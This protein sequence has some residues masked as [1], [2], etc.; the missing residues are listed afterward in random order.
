MRRMRHRGLCIDLPHPLAGKVP[1]VGNPIK[2]SETGI[3]YRKAPPMLGE[4]TERV[5]Q[6]I[7]RKS[8]D[9][10]AAL[11]ARHTI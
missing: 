8:A 6:E 9:D 3:E 4:D 10:I 7:L 11:R 1:G 2:F 5:L